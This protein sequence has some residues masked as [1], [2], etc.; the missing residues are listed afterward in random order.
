MREVTLDFGGPLGL[1][2]W[3]TVI[4]HKHLPYDPVAR[5]LPGVAPLDPTQWIIRDEVFAAQ[6]ALR[7]RLL[8]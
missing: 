1:A 2:V 5:P 4:L 8:S 6:M 7:D 3:M